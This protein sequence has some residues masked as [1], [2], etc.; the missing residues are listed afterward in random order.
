MS[1][2]PDI[3][4]ATEHP[5]AA[6]AGPAGRL[7]PRGMLGSTCLSLSPRT[8]LRALQ[9]NE[10]R[11]ST[12]SNQRGTGRRPGVTPTCRWPRSK[13]RRLPSSRSEFWPAGGSW[14]GRAP[15]PGMALERRDEVLHDSPDDQSRGDVREA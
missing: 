3:D 13:A 8:G 14:P 7:H 12:P 4:R 2:A 6:V 9:K 11:S 5:S 1:W 15:Q 10:R